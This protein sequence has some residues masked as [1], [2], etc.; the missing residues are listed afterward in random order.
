[1]TLRV[2]PNEEECLKDLWYR[3]RGAEIGIIPCTMPF[4][5]GSHQMFARARSDND[6]VV[7]IALPPEDLGLDSWGNRP[8][9]LSEQDRE[10]L[11]EHGVDGFVR[12][13]S[14]H[15][16]HFELREKKL[17]GVL[18]LEE[19]KVTELC[20]RFLNLLCRYA[21]RRLYVY[22]L[23][24]RESMVIEELVS[25]YFRDLEVIHCPL[26]REAGGLACSSANF[27][28]TAS[29]SQSSKGI[30]EILQTKF[31]NC[32]GLSGKRISTRVANALEDL[33]FEKVKIFLCDPLNKNSE[34]IGRHTRIFA[35]VKV[36][37]VALVDT[38][39]LAI[40]GE[41]D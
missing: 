25:E 24:Y 20:S 23:Y 8:V 6:W 16:E 9:D 11:I 34:T 29:E 33:E 31:Q 3:A 10:S 12:L 18:G 22:D 26:Q 39:S 4:H 14:L 30:F 15:S 5:L 32:I 21:P 1:M 36:R 27:F 28:L 41:Q 19:G 37:D 7:V 2:F 17:S 13:E 40:P 35:S 38:H